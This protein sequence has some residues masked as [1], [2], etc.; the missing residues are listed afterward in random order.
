MFVG[1]NLRIKARA[2]R[3]CLD[4]LQIVLLTVFVGLLA[5]GARAETAADEAAP[6]GCYCIG[7]VGNVNCDY[8]DE[9][10]IADVA[11]L[12]DHL[13]ISNLRLPNL[14]EA[15]ID[16][17]PAGEISLADVSLLIDHL[18]INFPAL[19]LCPQP[20]NT[21]PETEIVDYVKEWPFI[22][23]KVPG[24]SPITGV[25]MQWA[26]S[27]IVDHPYFPPDFE[28]QFRLYGPYSDSMLTAMYEQFVTRVFITNGGE[29]LRYGQPPDSVG[30]DTVWND[31]STEIIDI[32]PIWLPTHIISCDTVWYSG[33]TSEILCDT[34]LIDTLVSAN[35]YGR[36][37][38]LLD[39]E[40]ND[41]I[42]SV[43]N[44][45]SIS[46]SDGSDSCTYLTAD[47][48]FNVF[49]QYPS[50]TTV[51][52]NFIF[53]VR[54]RDPLDPNLFD[55]TPAF[56]K[57]AVIDAKHENDIVVINWSASSHENRALPDS[58]GMYW[59]RTINAWAQGK[60]ELADFTFD[61]SRDFVHVSSYT[62]NLRLVRLL[63]RYKMV[64]N[65]QDAEVSGTWSAYGDPVRRGVMW[66][67]GLGVNAWTAARV[68]IGN[69]TTGAG[70]SSR[71]ATEGY[72]YFFGVYTYHFPGWSAGFTNPHDGYGW[73]L[74]RT[75]DFIGATSSPNITDWP[76]LAIDTAN[77]HNRYSWKGS[78]EPLAF[79]FMP[80][81]PEIG[82]LPQVGWC[83]L[84]PEAEVL[85]NYVSLYEGEHP[86]VPGRNYNDKPVMHRLDRGLFRTVHSNFTP[87]ALE[88]TTAQQMVDSVLNW[89]Y[90]GSNKTSQ[91]QDQPNRESLKANDYEWLSSWYTNWQ[92]E[93]Q[94]SGVYI[95][96]T[97]LSDEG[98]EVR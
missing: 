31:D 94:A 57:L 96:D 48:M 2:P 92:Q 11:M 65:L 6:L 14:E 1:I 63:S 86:I 82:A 24:V 35:I 77:L 45:V 97:E 67:L 44:R 85:Y 80:F 87:L 20:Y 25:R 84:V 29:M 60:P 81:L 28:F 42:S 98:R 34:I 3:V 9:V 79:P 40:N 4:G 55:Q 51:E 10:T 41:F 88:E 32:N 5:L 83:D 38:T 53:W 27:D 12:I 46:S 43:F 70:I 49:Y 26:G 59:E 13:F 93:F 39:V 66:A 7:T 69:S 21:P 89:L 23:G 33:G 75:E 74:P 56:V 22:N 36:I 8:A 61:R 19:P 30:V 78:I 76:E 72:Q 54:T 37:D 52:A 47:S 95:G 90:L 91:R 71:F 68:P 18:F 64:I 50:D 15:N 58:I 73:G 16:G 62:L 17:D